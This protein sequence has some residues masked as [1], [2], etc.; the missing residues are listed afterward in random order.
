MSDC[1]VGPDGKLLDAS[2]IVWFNDPDDDAPLSTP[3]GLGNRSPSPKIAGSRRPQRAVRPSA[4][5]SDPNNAESTKAPKRKP[6]DAQDARRVSRKVVKADARPGGGEEHADAPAPLSAKGDKANSDHGADTHPEPD[7]TDAN[8]AYL[9]TKSMGD[10]DRQ[11][12]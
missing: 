12:K 11:V 2:E 5:A 10:A 8:A 1:A 6:E 9:A 7:D 4:K 3:K